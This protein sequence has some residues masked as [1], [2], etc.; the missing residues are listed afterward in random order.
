MYIV[1]LTRFAQLGVPAVALQGNFFFYL[2]YLLL[3]CYGVCKP[4]VALQGN[5]LFYFVFLIFCSSHLLLQLRRGT[6]GGAAR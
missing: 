2:L 5:F 6:R 4:A 1:R 3:L